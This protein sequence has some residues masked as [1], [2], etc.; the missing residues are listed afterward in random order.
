MG[1][2]Y[3]REDWDPGDWDEREWERRVSADT[4]ALM[5][6]QANKKSMIVAYLLLICFG[7][8]GAHRFYMQKTGSAAVMLTLFVIGFLLSFILIGVPIVL[9]LLV[10]VIV[11]AVNLAG[12]VHAYNSYLAYRLGQE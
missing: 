8:L 4:R 7:M 11:D 2:R 6:Y 5:M 9:I 10:W 12:W 1:D 3:D